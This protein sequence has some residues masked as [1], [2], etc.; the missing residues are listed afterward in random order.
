MSFRE[1]MQTKK[2]NAEEDLQ[3]ELQNRRLLDHV[4]NKNT[5]IV[6]MGNGKYLVV[7]EERLTFK[8]INSSEGF[9]VPDTILRKDDTSF[10][11]DGPPH[12]RVG[13]KNR[14]D[15]INGKLESCDIDYH[16][17]PYTVLSNKQLNEICNEIQEMTQK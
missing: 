1:R 15:R 6:F 12:L 4:Y 16:R 17:Y 14:D 9:T 13:V 8:L 7:P 3:I 10:Y 2:P 11:L 5:S